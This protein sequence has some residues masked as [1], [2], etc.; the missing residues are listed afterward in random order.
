MILEGRRHEGDLA[1]DADVVVVGS[2]ASGAVAARILAREGHDVVVVEEGGNVP[3]ERYADFRPTESFRHMYRDAGTTAAIGIGDTPLISIMAGRT[4]GGSSTLTGGVIFRIPEAVLQTWV[5][6]H[7]LHELSPRE[8]EPAYHDVEKELSVEEVPERMRSRSTL[9]FDQGARKL[10]FS[11]HSMRR[12]TRG[13]RGSSR[14]NFG[15]PHR[16][17]LSVDLTYLPR[18]MA[19]GARI[20]SDCR[21]DRIRIEGERAVG[22]E[23][24]L[25]DEN[26]R[27]RGRVTIRAAQVILAGGALSTPLLLQR[28]GVGRFTRQ[29]GRHLSLHPAARVAALFDEDVCGWKGAM[30]SA[31]SDDFQHEGLTLNSIYPPPNIITAMFPGF[32][33]THAAWARRMRQ[34]ATFGLMV[35]D[36]GGG[37]IY[38]L[39]GGRALY[40]YRMAPRD[41]VRMIRGVEL[42]ARAFFEAGAKEVLLPVFGARALRGPDELANLQSLP[43]RR[44]ECVTFHPLGSARMGHD[45]EASVVRPTGETHEVRNL[46]VVDGSVFPTSIGVNSQLPIMAVA[47]LLSW[48]LAERLRAGGR[49]GVPAADRV[50]AP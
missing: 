45:A 4:V 1:L 6:D 43:A 30:Q 35:H 29:V 3:P 16:A 49:R 13:C 34:V 18:A 41:K 9:L 22:V 17:K 12:N 44:F 7:G 15:C 26:L 47:T 28:A 31:Y 21:I 23:G 32:G 42:L 2:G 24:R 14:C 37:R 36:E 39:P 27:P 48:R 5:R 11:L 50:A 19:D 38:R 46:H 33:P 8:L 20:V 10:G 40:T 25:L